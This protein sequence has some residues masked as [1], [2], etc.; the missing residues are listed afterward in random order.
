MGTLLLLPI[1]KEEWRGDFTAQESSEVNS[2]LEKLHVF[3]V[4]K[5]L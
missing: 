1:Y 3:N 5:A 4:M 2:W